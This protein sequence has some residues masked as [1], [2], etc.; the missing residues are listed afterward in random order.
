MGFIEKIQEKM[1]KDF[2]TTLIEDLVNSQEQFHEMNISVSGRVLSAISQ[3]IVDGNLEFFK[4][5][6]T[7]AR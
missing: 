3:D 7:T 6:K 2:K 5:T 1:D 4:I